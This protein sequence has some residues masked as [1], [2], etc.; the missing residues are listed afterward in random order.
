MINRGFN[1]L[2]GLNIKQAKVGKLILSKLVMF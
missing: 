1:L 2:H